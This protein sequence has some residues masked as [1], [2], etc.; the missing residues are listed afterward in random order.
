MVRPSS[1]VAGSIPA[2]LICDTRP[3][4]ALG[5]TAWLMNPDCEGIPSTYETWA[6]FWLV[7]ALLAGMCVTLGW[8]LVDVVRQWKRR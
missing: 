2:S 1:M 8:M 6:C 5:G 3:G 4:S 7:L